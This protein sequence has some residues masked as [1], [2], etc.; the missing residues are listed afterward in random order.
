MS[1]EYHSEA[2]K[3]RDLPEVMKYVTGR[4]AD[5]GCGSDKI[6]PDAIGFDGRQLEGVDEQQDGLLHIGHGATQGYDTIFSSH[7]LEHVSNPHA[8]LWIWRTYLLP[9]G[10]LVLYMPHKGAYNSQDNPE[11]LYDWSYEDFLFFFKRCFCGEGK[12]YRGEHLPKMFELIDSG[13]DVGEN[14]YSFYLIAKKL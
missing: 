4:I 14:R 12:D 5:V 3:V 6:T 8:Y 13:L 1:K 10:H 2:A 9:G 11:H 7:F